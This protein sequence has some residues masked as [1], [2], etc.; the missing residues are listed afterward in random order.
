MEN[1]VSNE[2]LEKKR[3]V[4]GYQ[5]YLGLFDSFIHRASGKY[6]FIN[7]EIL[8]NDPKALKAQMS[9]IINLKET[10]KE[11]FARATELAIRNFFNSRVEF[12]KSL[13]KGELLAF[14]QELKELISPDTFRLVLKFLLQSEIQ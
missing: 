12:E 11:W 5:Y 1:T 9:N 2:H 3:L 10:P 14:D 8:S 6:N 13:T 4:S 7:D